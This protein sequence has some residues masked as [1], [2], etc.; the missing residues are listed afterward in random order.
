MGG[1]FDRYIEEVRVML[2]GFDAQNWDQAVDLLYTVRERGGRVFIAG[3]GGSAANS[4]HAAADFRKLSGIESYALLEN[5]AEL[6]AVT[7]DLSWESVF[8]FS[9]EHNKAQNPDLL[10]VFSVGGGNEEKRISLG[11]ISA[12]E[13]AKKKNMKVIS[14]VGR[15]DGF[16]AQNSDLV[17]IGET[18][19]SSLLTPI[20]ES[21]QGLFWHY[22]VS[23]P[24][25]AAQ[26]PVWK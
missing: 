10:M 12:I 2:D 4:I 11:L 5:I 19:D 8:Q 21:A 22:L 26:K 25:L 24:R 7:N 6:T 13:H 14:F 1:F 9:L 3:V 15:R 18:K 16:A 17:I 20:S 23:H